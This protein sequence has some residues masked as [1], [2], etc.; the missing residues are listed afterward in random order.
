MVTKMEKRSNPLRSHLLK[1]L[2]VEQLLATVAAVRMLW[3]SMDAKVGFN[4]YSSNTMRS[5]LLHTQQQL[6]IITK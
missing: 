4:R 2:Q 1:I 6:P 3:Q 5:N